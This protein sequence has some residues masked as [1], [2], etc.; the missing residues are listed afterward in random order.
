MVEFARK[1]PSHTG[2]LHTEVLGQM[3]QRQ[4]PLR[5]LDASLSQPLDAVDPAAGDVH[6]RVEE[7]LAHPAN[8]RQGVPSLSG[9]AVSQPVRLACQLPQSPSRRVCN[10]DVRRINQPGA[11]ASRAS[12]E[13][14]VI[15][16]VCGEVLVEETA[17]LEDAPVNPE[18][19]ASRAPVCGPALLI[20]EPRAVQKRRNR[21]ILPERNHD[22]TR[23][24][25]DAAGGEMP[26]STFKPGRV[27][28]AVCVRERND[29]AACFAYPQVPCGRKSNVSC[30]WDQTRSG[31]LDD[32]AGLIV[33]CVIDHDDLEP[34]WRRGLPVQ[35]V[36]QRRKG[37][38]AIAHGDHDRHVRRLT[39]FCRGRRHLPTQ[40]ASVH[41]TSGGAARDTARQVLV[42]ELRWSVVHISSGVTEALVGP[43]SGAN[44]GEHPA[45]RPSATAPVIHSLREELARALSSVIPA[46]TPV[47]VLD[48]PTHANVGDYAIWLG[49]LAYLRRAGHPVVYMCAQRDYSPERLV[50]RVGDGVILL[51]GGGNLGDLWPSHQSFRERVLRDFPGK[52][53][54]QLP[55]SVHFQTR[56]TVQSARRAFA[57]HPDFTLLAR[58]R[59]SHEFA[60]RE[61][62][63]RTALCPDS[64][65][66]LA[67]LQRKHAERPV[68]CLARTDHE[69][70][71]DLADLAGCDAIDWVHD[72]HALYPF[73]R[74][75]TFSAARRAARR[76][77]TSK[78]M[79]P[80]CWQGFEYLAETQV[81]L[82]QRLL[83][84]GRVAVTDRLHG[85]I[86]CLL[87]GV[88]HVM[89][90]NSYGKLRG[91]Y[92]TWTSG[93]ELT[94]WS[95]DPAQAMA[96]AAHWARELE[97]AEVS[98]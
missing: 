25:V 19:G 87:L 29:I 75:A 48:F 1:V 22:P 62:D 14:L 83:S 18:V 69:S 17:C 9:M 73:A 24:D 37:G 64:A 4:L 56:T 57:A 59:S 63:C 38:G 54:V 74:R 30:G 45:G 70:A 26:P 61:L 40:R 44:A 88:P 93:A 60:Q 43:H 53:I 7:E 81:R 80:L 91:F 2:E 68:I 5:R 85:H 13:V 89:M 51:H 8:R 66:E 98:P 12:R 23:E 72:P 50:E 47:A 32:V 71:A 34:F 20:E 94:R 39:A 65:V 33:R 27:R 78:L 42:L 90:D 58:D 55:Q 82:G 6:P 3:H 96:A 11:V 10:G 36:E 35:G 97:A 21:R 15:A 52:K 77:L 28:D 76:R 16:P 84:R 92:E 31:S 49:Q 95:Q 79:S 67:H 46:G 41:R 86:L